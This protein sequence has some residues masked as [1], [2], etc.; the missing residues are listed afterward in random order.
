MGEERAMVRGFL[1]D[2]IG[3]DFAGRPSGWLPLAE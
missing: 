2:L 1:D 3:P